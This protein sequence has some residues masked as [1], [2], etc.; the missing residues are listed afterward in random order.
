[1][2][3]KQHVPEE[4]D[5]LFR[6]EFYQQHYLLL[7]AINFL[8]VAT[9]IDKPKQFQY[10]I[11]YTKVIQWEMNVSKVNDGNKKLFPQSGNGNLF[12][13]VYYWN[14]HSTLLSLMKVWV[15]D[16]VL[17]SINEDNFLTHVKRVKVYKEIAWLLYIFIWHLLVH[18]LLCY[19]LA[20][21][22][23]QPH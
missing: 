20:L 5:F 19:C 10:F 15:T 6:T 9:L 7:P 23:T 3:K 17:T 18:V 2:E 13:C 8:N 1:M 21:Y 22:N 14:K 4:T 11:C 16:M 12:E